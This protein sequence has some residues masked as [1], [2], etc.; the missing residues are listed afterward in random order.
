MHVYVL[1]ALV[2]KEG[3]FIRWA[4]NTSFQSMGW[5]L[6]IYLFFEL[7]LGWQKLAESGMQCGAL[8]L[9]NTH[10]NPPEPVKQGCPIS[11]T[12]IS[13]VPSP[14]IH[15]GNGT[16]FKQLHSLESKLKVKRSFLGAGLKVMLRSLSLPTKHPYV[17][18][19]GLLCEA[20]QAVVDLLGDGDFRR[21]GSKR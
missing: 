4:F 9:N 3:S 11:L 14:L 15:Q 2:C 13:L 5:I 21:V 12:H 18:S 7:L 20:G 10:L 19:Q 17:F 1:Q 16:S 6:S 8:R